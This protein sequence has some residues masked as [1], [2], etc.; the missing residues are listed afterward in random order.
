MRKNEIA[1]RWLNILPSTITLAQQ[2]NS[3]GPLT[4]VYPAN[5]RLWTSVGLMFW[6]NAG[7]SSTT[8]AQ[9]WNN[10]GSMTSVF[11]VIPDVAGQVSYI[12]ALTYTTSQS[13]KKERAYFLGEQLQSFGFARPWR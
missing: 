3:V 8:L 5:T 11:C 7:P 13:Q 9:H 6:F 1:T 12:S 4:N 2:R 10:N